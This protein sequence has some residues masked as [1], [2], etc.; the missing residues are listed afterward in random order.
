MIVLF[1][2][3]GDRST[4]RLIDW[5]NYIECPF[6]RINIEEEDFKNIK[7]VI[8]NKKINVVFVLNNG[9]IIDFSKVDFFYNRGRK[10]VN[11]E[12]KNESNIPDEIYGKYLL[13]EYNSITNFFYDEVNKKS[14]GCF[15]QDSHSKLNQLFFAQ[16][17]LLGVPNSVIIN[18]K[19]V[20]QSYF[21]DKKIITKA[22]HENIAIRHKG[23]FHL[24]RVQRTDLQNIPDE[25]F[26]SLFQNE[27]NKEYEIRSYYLDGKFFTIRFYS[28]SENIDMRDNYLQSRFEPYRLPKKTENS[29]IKVMKSLKLLSGSIDMIR[30]KEGIY[31]YLE[32]NPNGQYDWVSQYGGYQSDKEIALYLKSKISI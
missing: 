28:D 6:K 31:Y 23:Q 27:I 20:L 16:K 4:N 21:E 9:E 15:Q 7:I 8:A 18:K 10:F 12:L 32:V 29:L 26:P 13:Q 14:V 30:S 11:P 2:Y 3:N 25:F 17:Y 19:K 24:Q 22:I 5:L 1:S